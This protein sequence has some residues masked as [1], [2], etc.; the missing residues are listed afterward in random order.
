[1]KRGTLLIGAVVLLELVA[2]F[3]IFNFRASQPSPPIPNLEIVDSLTSEALLAAA[4][5]CKSPSDWHR[6]AQIYMAYGFYPEA[7]ATFAR[8]AE[9]DPAS[10]DYAFDY[11]F[12]LARIGRAEESNRQFENAI[13]LGHP[14]PDAANFFVA[15]NYLR[16]EDADSAEQY[17]RKSSQIP[18]AKF[19]LA[20][21]LFRR[22]EYDESESL[23]RE[24]LRAEPDAVQPYVLLAQVAQNRGDQQAWYSNSIE[25]A[26]K[27]VRMKSP[28]GDERKELME[29]LSSVGYEKKLQESV[30]LVAQ[31]QNM[32]ARRGLKALQ[33]VEWNLNA[34]EALIRCAIQSGQIPVSVKLIEERMER[35]GPSSLWL[36]RL[37]ESQL[38]MGDSEAAVEAWIRGGKLNSDKTGAEC[39]Q[40]LARYL[41]QSKDD[42]EASEKYQ[43]LG[44]LGVIRDSLTYEK[45]DEALGYARAAVEL[46]PSSAE[47]FF[48]LG[49]AEL[50]V[51]KLDNAIAAFRKCLELTPTHGRARRQLKALK[52]E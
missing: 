36:K 17:F 5:D 13:E 29:T 22:G 27:W 34:Q 4:G 52:V 26:N 16:L 23:L 25:G 28:F 40:Y 6:L 21:I 15:R 20:K 43:A 49:R 9:L 19:E 24:S 31:K 8:A 30:V 14:N 12:C 46:D 45:Y 10:S 50:G 42:V 11:A 2:C 1:M 32:M 37:A 35:F 38:A 39:Y 3:L 47:A 44:I 18:L 51:L 33:E 41:L 48:L 7:R